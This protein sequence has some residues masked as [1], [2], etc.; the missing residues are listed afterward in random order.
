MSNQEQENQN[1]S[2]KYEA[3]LAE[4][5]PEVIAERIGEKHRQ[6]FQN[7]TLDVDIN[8]DKAFFL[9]LG[10]FYMNQCRFT[11]KY[12]PSFNDCIEEARQYLG[13][14]EVEAFKDSKEN[15]KEGFIGVCQKIY[16]ALMREEEVAYI[17]SVVKKYI[18]IYLYEEKEQ[19]AQYYC[20]TRMGSLSDT[21]K[22]LRVMKIAQNIDK[23]IDFYVQKMDASRQI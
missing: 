15:L 16:E 4:I 23:F 18:N 8:D 1:I 17:K 21:D 11:G 7:N 6:A 13:D 3:L 20:G 19:F 2:N 22:K 5:D 9:C 14:S 10:N 12:V